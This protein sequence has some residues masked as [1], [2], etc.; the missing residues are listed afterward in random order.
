MTNYS[1]LFARGTALMLVVVA[2]PSCLPLTTPTLISLAVDGFSFMATGKTVADH[3]ISGIA[4]RD[5]SIGRAVLTNTY[6][7]KDEANPPVLVAD[8]AVSATENH[9]LMVEQMELA[10]RSDGGEDPLL[11]SRHPSRW[12][13]PTT[14]STN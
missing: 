3:A 9:A 14:G 8:N 4:Q 2:L 10:G 11:S 7:C 12:P 13:T 5:C 1:K 6:L